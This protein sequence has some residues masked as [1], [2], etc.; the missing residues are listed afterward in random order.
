MTSDW[1]ST[2]APYVSP[3]RQ[4]QGDAWSEEAAAQGR[5][6][7]QRIIR[8][9]EIAPPEEVAALL[10]LDDDETS[11][12]RRRIMYLD[13]EPTELADSY[14]PLSLA[15]G[16]PLADPAKIRGG[17]V[18]LLASLG[19]SPH[20]VRED[21]RARM[22]YPAEKAELALGDGEP[23]LCLTRLVLDAAAV[24]FQVDVSVFPAARQRLRYEMKVG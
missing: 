9:G 4:G 2:S 3:R 18:T 22:P 23:V 13:G 14:Y 5:K 20:R 7:T 16:T 19:H 1:V 15:G 17:A 24:P 12:V 11:V 6:G 21:V 10:G 8:A